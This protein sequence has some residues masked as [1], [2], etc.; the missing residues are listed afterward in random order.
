[1]ELALGFLLL[2]LVVV[3]A[4]TLQDAPPVTPALDAGLAPERPALLPMTFK[5]SSPS[6]PSSPS[7]SSTVVQV[8]APDGRAGASLLVTNPARVASVVAR[9]RTKAVGA[10]AVGTSI[11]IY[12][13]TYLPDGAERGRT[14][15]EKMTLVRSRETTTGPLVFRWRIDKAPEVGPS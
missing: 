11:E 10:K 7:P 4:A 9:E 2:L 15:A 6:S 12:V 1:M 14:L 8:I 3:V 5:P 13:V